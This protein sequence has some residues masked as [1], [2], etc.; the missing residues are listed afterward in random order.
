MLAKH[1]GGKKTAGRPQ[2][3]HLLSNP[4]I[5]SLSI[6]GMWSQIKKEKKKSSFHS[7]SGLVCVVIRW[8]SCSGLR[9]SGAFFLPFI[10]AEIQIYG[11]DNSVWKGWDNEVE[12]L[13]WSFYLSPAASVTAGG[14]C[15]RLFCLLRVF[16]IWTDFTQTSSHSSLWGLFFSLRYPGVLKLSHLHGAAYLGSPGKKLFFFPVGQAA[17]IPL[18]VD[19]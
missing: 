2:S 17:L 7:A 4:C 12:A 10:C 3:C 18:P 5:L 19:K 13:C 11:W 16:D 14:I 6:P 9:T 1:S 15:Q 8:T